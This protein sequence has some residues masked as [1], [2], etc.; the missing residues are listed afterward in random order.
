MRERDSKEQAGS[1]S[2]LQLLMSD[3]GQLSLG[4]LQPRHHVIRILISRLG[5][6]R[7]YS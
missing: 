7:L 5:K 6:V 4:I 2:R 1:S 3:I